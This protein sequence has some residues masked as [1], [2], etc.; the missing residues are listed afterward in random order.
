MRSGSSLMQRLLAAVVMVLVL[1]AALAAARVPHARAEPQPNSEYEGSMSDGGIVHVTVDAVSKVV[2]A[3]FDY[4]T[5]PNGCPVHAYYP[6]IPISD[7]GTQFR[8]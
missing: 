3:Y 6:A 5:V 2:E 1:A 4:K 7:S 8:V